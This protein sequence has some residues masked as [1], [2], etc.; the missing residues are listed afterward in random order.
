MF[1]VVVS[2]QRWSQ[3]AAK[4]PPELARRPGEWPHDVR[5]DLP[6]CTVTF[7]VTDVE[8]STT[9]LRSLGLR[10][11][12]VLDVV[13]SCRIEAGDPSVIQPLA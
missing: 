4:L 3:L 12:F 7:L 6:P 8:G 13:H 11:D 10:R 1:A 9:L 2:P 5:D